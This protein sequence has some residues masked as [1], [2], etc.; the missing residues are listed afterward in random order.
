MRRRSRGALAED[1]SKEPGRGP[2]T[3]SSERCG[4][5]FKLGNKPVELT[6]PQVSCRD[7]RWTGLVGKV[8]IYLHPTFAVL[9]RRASDS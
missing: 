2:R 9:D 8:A 3:G 5:G 4:T 1:I 7:D 6:F